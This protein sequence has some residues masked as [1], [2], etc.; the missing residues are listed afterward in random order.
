MLV[1][2]AIPVFTAQLERSREAVD[3]AN[4]RAG[5]AE[6]M[7]EMLASGGTTATSTSTFTVKQQDKSGWVATDIDWTIFGGSSNAP[8]M[9]GIST[10]K[11]QVTSSGSAVTVALNKVS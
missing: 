9:T 11:V 10:Y 6:A 7:S 3:A 1:A 8:D 5:Y 2:V 4:I